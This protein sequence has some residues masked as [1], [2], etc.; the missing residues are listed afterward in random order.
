MNKK[1]IIQYSIS[2]IKKFSRDYWDLG[3]AVLS[4]SALTDW[5][6]ETFGV[7]RTN[8]A[9][10]SGLPSLLAGFYQPER[11]IRNIM[12]GFF[13]AQLNLMDNAEEKGMETYNYAFMTF[14]TGMSAFGEYLRYRRIKSRIV[15]PQ[16]LESSLS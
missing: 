4:A 10:W 13:T 7:Y 12:A 6:N 8:I 1:Q 15:K 14:T 16:S 2:A 9:L 11:G 3:A 5:N